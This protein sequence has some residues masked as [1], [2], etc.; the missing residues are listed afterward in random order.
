MKQPSQHSSLDRS[1]QPQHL[2]LAQ[3]VLIAI[4]ALTTLALLPACGSDREP[5]QPKVDVA[6]LVAEESHRQVLALQALAAQG[7]TQIQLEA[8]ELE[9]IFE[10]REFPSTCTRRVQTGTRP[11]CSTEWERSCR[12]HHEEQCRQVDFPICRDVREQVCRNV[13]EQVCRDE[14]VPVCR[15]QTRRVCETRQNCRTEDTR[16]CDSRGCRTVPRRVCDPVQS[17]R[18]VS[19]RVCENQT[20]RRC[21]NGSRRECRMEDRRV[22]HNE[23]RRE[24]RQVPREI[25]ENIPRQSCR[26]VPVFGDQSYPCT[27]TRRVAVGERIRFKAMAQVNLEFKNA[28]NRTVDPGEVEILLDQDQIRV[29]IQGPEAAKYRIRKLT[30][31]RRNISETELQINESYLIELI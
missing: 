3:L 24:C 12:T 13:P 26:D 16:I 7:R 27:E 23:S 5:S 30:S 31:E 8:V 14:V 22:C 15:N 25:C 4:G 10:D 6:P 29:I 11:E 21:E 17:C 1:S 18:D 9:S 19:E 28:R 20:R 2:N